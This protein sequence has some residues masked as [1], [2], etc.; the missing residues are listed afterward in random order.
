[1]HVGIPKETFPGERRVALVPADVPKLAKA[2][3]GVIVEPGAGLAAGF[4][5]KNGVSVYSVI[6]TVQKVL[7]VPAKR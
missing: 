7:A 5:D 3:I 1:M 2:G 4:A 6:P